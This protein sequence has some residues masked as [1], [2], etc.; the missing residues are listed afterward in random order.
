M[1]SSKQA[2]KN[3]KLCVCVVLTLRTAAFHLMLTQP[4]D[5]KVRFWIRPRLAFCWSFLCCSSKSTFKLKGSFV[6]VNRRQW[7]HTALLYDSLNASLSLDHQLSRCFSSQHYV[8]KSITCCSF[9]TIVINSV[10]IDNALIAFFNA[11]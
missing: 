2:I 9:C 5:Y 10:I 7:N 6:V 3:P 11:N 8:P 1:K 4:L